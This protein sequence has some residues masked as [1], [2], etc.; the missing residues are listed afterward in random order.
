MGTTTVWVLVFFIGGWTHNGGPAVVDNIA[1]A[2]ECEKL[3]QAIQ[4][5]RG[6]ARYR[7]V[8]VAKVK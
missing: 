7:C 8:P 2:Q 3:A 1:S 6:E 4:D 5:I